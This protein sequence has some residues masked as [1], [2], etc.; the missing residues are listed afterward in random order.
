MSLPT[1]EQIAA[2]IRR[3]VVGLLVSRR[4]DRFSDSDTEWGAGGRVGAAASMQGLRGVFGALAAL[5]EDGE[6]WAIVQPYYAA[7]LQEWEAMIADLEATNY[8]PDPYD[9]DETFDGLRREADGTPAPYVDTIAWAVSTSVMINYLFPLAKKNWGVEPDTKIVDATRGE[10]ARSVRRLLSLRLED[11][12]WGWG[13]AVDMKASHLYFTWTAIQGLA[14]FFDYILGDS[15]DEIGVP[16]DEY[17][18][19]D[20]AKR[21]PAL[22]ADAVKARDAA[23][24]CLRDAYLAAALSSNY[25]G[26][27]DLETKPQNSNARISVVDHGD[28]PLLYFYSYLLE[29]LILSSYDKNNPA[30]VNSRRGEMD[31]LYV[32]IKRRFAIVRPKSLTARLDA[33]KSTA[34]IRLSGEQ[35]RP[36]G[37]GPVNSFKVNDPSLW[38]QILRTLVLYPYYVERP[39]LPDEDIV[40]PSGAYALLLS[41]RRTEQQDGAHLWDRDGFNLALTTRAL[42]GLI[43]VYDYVCLLAKKSEEEKVSAPLALADVLAEA[44]YP[45]L[46]IRLQADADIVPKPVDGSGSP[47][48]SVEVRKAALTAGD[49]ALRK[50]GGAAAHLMAQRLLTIDSKALK[51]FIEQVVGKEHDTFSST[52][53]AAYQ[54]MRT[55][56]VTC[57]VT[58]SRLL[59]QILQEAIFAVGTDADVAENKES[60][61]GDSALYK[62]IQLAL[63]EMMRHEIVADDWSVESAVRQLLLLTEAPTPPPQ[64]RGRRAS[65]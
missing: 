39:K 28:I 16:I 38:P 58:T 17:T 29:A 56:I 13:R 43:D 33:T 51:G 36:R 35:Q 30:V 57:L 8:G 24:Q 5:P 12:G 45:Q 32:E 19:K 1:A 44:L 15:V 64:P 46:R 48:S 55:I 62:R 53:P 25:L 18:R 49:D 37:Q 6:L 59:S 21:D 34:E 54:L 20:L 61:Q 3:T 23:A 10:I 26:F 14:D 65:A 11:G 4:K 63:Q 9:K 40:G 47:L 50:Q 60:F 31:R 27:A 7:L 2:E 52:N 22:E 41:D 42:E